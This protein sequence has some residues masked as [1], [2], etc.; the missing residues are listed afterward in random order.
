MDGEWSS[1]RAHARRLTASLRSRHRSAQAV[2]GKRRRKAAARRHCRRG[3]RETNF[4]R[5]LLLVLNQLFAR[6][7]GCGRRQ[8]GQMSLPTGGTSPFDGARHLAFGA[9]SLSCRNGGGGKTRASSAVVVAAA[10]RAASDGDKHSNAAVATQDC[11]LALLSARRAAF[12]ATAARLAMATKRNQI[13]IVPSQTA[14]ALKD[15]AK[16]QFG[17]AKAQ[18]TAANRCARQSTAANQRFATKNRADF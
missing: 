15:D 11:S 2:R 10:F 3:R 4:R 5:N 7:V 17:A 6:F 1:A 12:S 16:L 18:P 14:G 8:S 9:A 13:W